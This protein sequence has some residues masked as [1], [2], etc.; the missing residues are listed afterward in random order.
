VFSLSTPQLMF[1]HQRGTREKVMNSLASSVTS[2]PRSSAWSIALGVLLVISGLLSIAAPFF[3]GIA[4]SVFFG[5]L[6]LFAGVAHLVYAW[7][8]KRAGAVFWQILIGIVYVIA[9]L[10]ML[11]LPVAGI[12]ALTVMLG[13]Y[14]TIEGIVEIIL[15]S[16]IREL[17]GAAW[18]LIDG[19]LSLLLAGLI[20]FHWPSS[21]FWVLG[22]LVGIS[23]LFSG[24]ARI[25]LSAALSRI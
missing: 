25:T 22:T 21:S 23:L 4:A 3:A 1:R 18:F 17:R 24:V 13:F 5:W 2:H 19:L 7:S 9:A 16:L 11:F 20:F 10:C 14:M 15:F 12:V 8:E 6:V